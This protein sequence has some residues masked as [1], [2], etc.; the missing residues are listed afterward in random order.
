M[1]YR[2]EALIMFI[3]MIFFFITGFTLLFYKD[4]CLSKRISEKEHK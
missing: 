1:N 4:G 2:L 3:A